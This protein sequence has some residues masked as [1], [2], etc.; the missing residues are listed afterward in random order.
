MQNNLEA[1]GRMTS[2]D[3]ALQRN[4]VLRNTYLLLALSLLPTAIGALFGVQ[5]NFAFM[6]GSPILS[7]VLFLAVA[8][9]FMWGIE[10]TKNSG[11]GIVLLLGFTFLMG[12]L[13]GPI[14]QVSLGFRNGGIL[15]AT[16]A[17]GTSIIFLT[18]AGIATVTKKDFSF[19]GKFLFIGVI[20]LLVAMLANIFLQLPALALTISSV[21]VLIFSAYILYD[22]SRIVTGGESNYVIATLSI[23]LDIYNLFVHLLNLLLAFSGER[24]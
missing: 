23:Y 9:G 21:A 11:M 22:V 18:L 24:D 15:I 13:L 20:L 4:R 3:L 6:S 19:M 12:L 17:A 8:W 14:L 2:F 7:F 16:A 1:V 10:R 5:I